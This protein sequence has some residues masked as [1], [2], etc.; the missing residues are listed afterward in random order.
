M[1]NKLIA[2]KSSIVKVE[3]R[4]LLDTKLIRIHE[5]LQ[6]KTTKVGKEREEMSRSSGKRFVRF[7][8]EL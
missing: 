2:I 4:V 7:I 1:N 3:V 5:R 8:N 6:E